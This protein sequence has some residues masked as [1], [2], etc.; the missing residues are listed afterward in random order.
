MHPYSN[1]LVTGGAGFIGSHFIRFLLSTYPHITVVNVDLLTYC[2]NLEN[3]KDVSND[4]RYHFR[5][6]DIGDLEA[7][8]KILTELCIDCI[9]NFAAESDNNKAVLSPLDFVKTNVLGTATLLSAARKTSVKRF[10]HISTCEVFG[11]LPLTS[12][13][14][15][16]EESPYRPRTPYNASKASSDLFV[17]SYY[18]T[19][20]L[21]VTISYSANNYGTHQFPEKVIPVFTLKALKNEPLPLFASTGHKRE[22]IHVLDHSKAIDLILQKGVIGE[23]Y[24]IGTGF[25]KT[26]SE[27][28]TDILG[29]LH[30][31]KSMTT[32]VPDRL[33]DD[34]RYLL[35]SSKVRALGWKPE[36]V[37]EK[38]LAETVEWYAKNA[39]WWEPLLARS[40]SW[41]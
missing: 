25:E 12:P 11:E 41:K 37:W 36:I 22:W 35:D 18:H 26:I 30:K 8:E 13:E 33:G 16:V 21:P 29:I 10:H 40:H 15:F 32:I 2:G 31:P 23:G 14:R 20:G 1:I 4:P 5:K 3:V 28:A 17:K 7:M 39:Q 34:S 9:V 6:A 19:F 24:N 38:G 27:V